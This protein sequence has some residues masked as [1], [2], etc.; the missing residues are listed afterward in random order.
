[1]CQTDELKE[2]ELDGVKISPDLIE[3][4]KMTQDEDN[5]FLR[6]NIDAVVDATFHLAS[7]EPTMDEQQLKNIRFSLIMG[8]SSVRDILKRLG[9]TG[10]FSAFALLE[11]DLIS[12][13]YDLGDI[14]LY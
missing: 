14:Y 9:R 1:M 2:Y 8:L 11:S 4:L 13:L 12:N 5:E 10:M 3:L 6:A 7:H